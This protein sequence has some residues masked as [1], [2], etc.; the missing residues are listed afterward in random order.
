MSSLC[1]RT[2]GHHGLAETLPLFAQREVSA[3]R[4]YVVADGHDQSLYEGR[5]AARLISASLS[6][7]RGK[8]QAIAVGFGCIAIHRPP[9]DELECP[10]SVYS[11]RNSVAIRPTGAAH[12]ARNDERARRWSGCAPGIIGREK[13]PGIAPNT[14][15]IQSEVAQHSLERFALIEHHL[16][17][18][19]CHHD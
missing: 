10:G 5:A 17:V 16:A 4:L 19:N 9:S 1:A 14:S 18:L 15:P 3:R 11:P 6:A 2:R 13:T 7:G 12:R 8:K